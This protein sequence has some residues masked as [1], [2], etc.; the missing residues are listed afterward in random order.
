MNWRI[1]GLELAHPVLAAPM[2]GV[3]DKAF[4][5][6]AREAGAALVYTEMLSARAL[7]RESR[8]TREMLD[9]SGEQPPVA[10]QIF[11]NDPR[12]MAAAARQAEAAGAALVDINMGCPT[13]KVVKN[14]DGAA[15][16]R[17]LPRALDIV[18]ACV[19]AVRVPVTVKMRRGWEEGEEVAP[20]LAAAAEAAGASAVAVHGRFRSQFY[21][22]RADWPAIR[23]VVEAVRI[24]VIGNGDVR[25]PRDAF[26]LLEETGCRAVMIGRA[27]LGN[28]WIFGRVARYLERGEE[29]PPPPPAVRVEMALRHLRLQ[30][31]YKGEQVG[32]RQMRKHLAWYLRG[33][34]G[35][36]S[37]RQQLHRVESLAEAEAVLRSIL[38][39]AAGE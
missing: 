35:A 20:E 23:R 39:E 4:R 36:A 31:R 1:G 3:T 30:V 19:E 32:V 34:P 6:L 14:G 13:P 10:V 15:L 21:Q 12:E 7:A 17:D 29:V 33:L 22:G 27:A 37:L 28:P 26:L 25:S 18:R 8:R 11:G 16:L 9:L 24:P 38:A 2:A 5:L